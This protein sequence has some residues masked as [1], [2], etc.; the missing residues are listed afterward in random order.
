MKND[1]I[2]ECL[3]ND[4]IDALETYGE[5]KKAVVLG[6]VDDLYNAGMGINDAV[7]LSFEALKEYN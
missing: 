6:L 4:Q 7:K 3:S 1:I 5:E 2:Y